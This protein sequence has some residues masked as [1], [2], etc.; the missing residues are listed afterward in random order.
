M[1]LLATTTLRTV[2]FATSL[3]ALPISATS[4]HHE[5]QHDHKTREWRDRESMV[6]KSAQDPITVATWEEHAEN[7][8]ENDHPALNDYED[9][10]LRRGAISQARI[11][12]KMS[13]KLP[14]LRRLLGG[15]RPVTFESFYEGLQEAGIVLDT[16]DARVCTG[17]Q[18]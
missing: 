9:R 1:Q 11:N 17:P 4:P 7:V 3:Y 16:A 5:S 13:E 15:T 2:T 6:T 8:P 18:R 14:D 10:R 12:W